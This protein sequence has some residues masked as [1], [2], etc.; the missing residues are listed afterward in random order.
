MALG[1]KGLGKGLSSLLGEEN[2]AENSVSKIKVREIEPNPNQPRRQFEEGALAE[3]AESIRRNGVITPIA[4]RKTQG[5]Y[6]IIAG[7]R[8]WRA[9]RLAGL[10]EIPALVIEADDGL[11]FEL[12]LIENLQ[13]EDLNPLE[14]AEGYKELL[15]RF[16]LT[17][18]EVAERVGKS[19]PSVANSLRLLTLPGSL[20]TLVREG[21][22]SQG[23]AR[24]LL[25]IGQEETMLRAAQMVL[26]Q[27]LSV[28]QTEQL[29]KRLSKL[30]E[31]VEQAPD[32]Q[33]IY[34]EELQNRL[35]HTTGR[36][37]QISQSKDKSKGKITIEYFDNEDLDTMTQMLVSLSK[38]KGQ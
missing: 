1:S 32:V 18:E 26:D 11:A 19:R 38:K 33:Q 31:V 3:L 21:T 5:G 8:R 36:R 37:I 27:G 4:L 10:E 17:Q 28:R 20:Q 22:L 30:E 7:E 34:V 29:V 15:E 13:R 24:T 35:S 9:S 6:Q 14:E 16:D 2:M 23:H 12:A 25:G